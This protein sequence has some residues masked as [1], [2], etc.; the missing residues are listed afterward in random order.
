MK[1]QR[2]KRSLR[3]WV[4]RMLRQPAPGAYGQPAV[5]RCG[6]RMEIEHF[7]RI[8]T[9]D[10]EKLCLEFRRGRLTIYGDR[11]RIETLAAHRITLR[12]TVLR[13]EFSSR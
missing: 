12:G 7:Q 8:L 2:K 13:T 1:K 5:Y 3:E 11:M 9:Y 4:G 6:S 10:D